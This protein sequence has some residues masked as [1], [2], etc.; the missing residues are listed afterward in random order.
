M[1]N[2]GYTFGETPDYRRNERVS[3]PYLCQPLDGG[4]YLIDREYADRFQPAWFDAPGDR[5]GL[6][7]G[8]GSVGVIAT[9]IGDL[10]RRPYLRGGLPRHVVRDRYLWTGAERTRSFRE[11]L[12]T[13]AL[14][15]AGAPVPEPVGACY[16]RGWFSYRAV[17][18]TRLIPDAE[19]LLNRL[20]RS[21]DGIGTLLEKAAGAIACLHAHR[22]WH[23][24]L[25]A[26]NLLVD[27]NDE[28]WL[29][30][31]DRAELGAAGPGR[32]AGNL[33]RLLRSLRKRLPEPVMAQVE[34]AWPD[35][36]AAYRREFNRLSAEFE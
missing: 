21:R 14:Y 26:T 18:L 3:I 23:A 32:L 17:L 6:Q 13:H 28:V 25:N 8:R 29:I 36:I 10:V 34:D 35:V 4:E 15:H 9:P 12:I 16:R 24:D 20:L 7:G 30:D 5:A 1:G 11:Y 33:D 27:A 19:T 31:F 2:A 22:V